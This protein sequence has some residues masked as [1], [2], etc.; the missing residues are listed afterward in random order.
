MPHYWGRGRTKKAKK[1]K[2]REGTR[3]A[4]AN[5]RTML[6]IGLPGAAA[7]AASGSLNSPNMFASNFPS[8][9][10]ADET[11]PLPLTAAQANLFENEG[12]RFL[13]D[14]RTSR[15]ILAENA[16]LTAVIP[17][18]DRHG[19]G[20]FGYTTS[21]ELHLKG[22]GDRPFTTV[23]AFKVA[24]KDPAEIETTGVAGD[25]I[26][27][28]ATYARTTGTTSVSKCVFAK[29][30]PNEFRFAMEHYLMDLHKLIRNAGLPDAERNRLARVLLFQTANG[31]RELHEAGIL[32]KDL[33]P[34]NVLLSHSGHAIVIDFGL[35][36]YIADNIAVDSAQKLL[37]R[38]TTPTIQPPEASVRSRQDEPLG[39]SYD[40]WGLGCCFDYFVNAEYNFDFWQKKYW[41]RTVTDKMFQ[42]KVDLIVDKFGAAGA[43][44][45]AISL[46]KNML[47]LDPKKRPTAAE[48]LKDPYFEGLT[49]ADATREVQE[50]LGLGSFT[51]SKAKNV[52]GRAKRRGDAGAAENSELAAYFQIRPMPP[53][54]PDRLFSRPVPKSDVAKAFIA[55]L[56]PGPMNRS[57]M[58]YAWNWALSRVSSSSTKLPLYAFFHSLELCERL[59]KSAN[60]IAQTIDRAMAA[61]LPVYTIADKACPMEMSHD[62]MDLNTITRIPGVTASKADVLKSEIAIIKRLGGDVYPLKDGFVEKTLRYLFEGDG[63]NDGKVAAMRSVVLTLVYFYAPGGTKLD[64]IF[65][66]A[67]GLERKFRNP[68]SSAGLGGS[69]AALL[70]EVLE[71]YSAE[72]GS[73]S[74]SELDLFLF[75]SGSIDG[76]FKAA[77][78]KRV[79]GFAEE[80]TVPL[81][82]GLTAARYGI[83]VQAA[84]EL[85][86]YVW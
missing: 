49:V 45:D 8:P 44:G 43:P 2:G 33:K 75:H 7:R 31:L 61:I 6:S 41:T 17:S 36:A 15:R 34:E 50:I 59:F 10:N 42:D 57:A 47:D 58:R 18:S 77:D 67:R 30:T 76:G 12:P 3:R 14:G 29:L 63:E 79:L 74:V 65:A 5:L 26:K 56:P 9:V 73:P 38:R 83:F 71:G 19:Q 66:V 70:R 25:V 84:H 16:K 32:H 78:V 72:A 13:L 28:L 62:I 51:G 40:I 85:P 21:A 39:P 1:S 48:V 86:F 4:I 64:D 68:N 35:S 52:L 20:S 27:E 24:T 81:L 46:L 82:A 11:P 69:A 37:F 80:R 22:A 54:Q 60:G 55:G 53:P 23:A